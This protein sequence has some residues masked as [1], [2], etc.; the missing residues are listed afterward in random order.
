LTNLDIGL[1]NTHSTLQWLPAS[2][3]V[4]GI[5]HPPLIGLRQTFNRNDAD[6]SLV[7][8][9]VARSESNTPASLT[10][11][12]HVRHHEAYIGEY[13]S[14]R[15]VFCPIRLHP[16][17]GF[18]GVLPRKHLDERVSLVLVHNARLYQAEL[19]K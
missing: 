5:D 2:A 6:A 1:F 13:Y 11:S 15:H 18:H 12:Q 3:A 8:A 7:I 17:L 14:E 16:R 9:A 10:P 4:L 19:L